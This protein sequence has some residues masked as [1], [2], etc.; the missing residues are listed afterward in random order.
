MYNIK[1]GDKAFEILI[2]GETV[3]V[4]G[5][6][7][8]FDLVHLEGD[9]HHL[10]LDNQSYTLEVVQ[11]DLKEKSIAVKVNNELMTVS[12]KTEMDLLLSKMGL[13]NHHN[14]VARDIGAPM[15]GL[16]L[17]VVVKEGD[18]VKKGDKL[19]VLEAMK[20][21]NIIKSPGDGKIKSIAVAKG[22]SVD[23]GQKLIHFE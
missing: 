2:K 4:N 7:Q 20:M 14:S 17:D 9:R 10:I 8:K 12:V 23:S 6:P 1:V 3:E 19:L 18:E 5:K 13:N 11:Y 15:P 16:I 21:E 22:E